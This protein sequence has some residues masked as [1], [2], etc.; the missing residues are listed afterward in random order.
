MLALLVGERVVLVVRRSTADVDE[1]D[2]IDGA[3]VYVAEETGKE[4]WTG[5]AFEDLADV[6]RECSL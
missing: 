4:R 5:D 1:G 2:G 3:E 6:I